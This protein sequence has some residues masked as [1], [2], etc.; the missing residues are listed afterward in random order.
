MHAICRF[1]ISK[2]V[3]RSF[4]TAL[5][6]LIGPAANASPP[7][8][9][10]LHGLP[11]G[12]ALAFPTGS[13]KFSLALNLYKDSSGEIIVEYYVKDTPEGRVLFYNFAKGLV[14]NPKQASLFSSDNKA[15][16]AFIADHGWRP[17]DRG[18]D[19]DLGYVVHQW[20]LDNA[21]GANAH[22]AGTFR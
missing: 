6:L 3:Q 4:L 15:L 12:Q 14:D 8:S 21:L 2:V 18:F 7:S 9:A 17:L 16:S 11:L 10:A 19:T 5:C 1:F 22:M 20:S 13:G